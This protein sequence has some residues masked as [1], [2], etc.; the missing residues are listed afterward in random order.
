MGGFLS[1]ILPAVG[2]VL[3]TIGGSF[4]GAPQIGGA[5]GNQLGQAGSRGLNAGETTGNHSGGDV[6]Q[7]AFGTPNN[8]YNKNPDWVNTAS[9]NIFTNA[10]KAADQP[11]TPYTG[12]QV[13]PLSS[14]QQLAATNAANAVGRYAPTYGAI[15]DYYNQSA[16]PNTATYTAGAVTPT[17]VSTQN[18]NQADIG[19]YMN[20]YLQ[21]SLN[22]QINNLNLQYAN[23]QNQANAQAAGSGNF[24]GSR[25][26]VANALINKQQNQ[27]IQNVEANGYNNAFNTAASNW[28]ADQA[29]NLQGQLANQ[30]AGI[31]TGEFNQTQNANAFTTNQNIAQQNRLAQQAAAAGLTALTGQQQSNAN[32]ISNNLMTTGAAQQQTQQ[33]QD[34]AKYQDYLNQMYYPE[35]QAT[36]L[37]SILKGNPAAGSVGYGYSPGNNGQG[38]LLGQLTNGSGGGILGSITNGISG[39]FGGGSGSSASGT[40]SSSFNPSSIT[41]QFA[42]AGGGS[43]GLNF[44]SS[45]FANG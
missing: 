18:F 22:P 36:F 7:N 31:N 42:N 3:G 40:G 27:D 17:N 1:S 14:N 9:Q 23:Q 24:G 39:L 38:N 37:S 5:I 41:N 6:I 29:R 25:Q 21:A 32:A 12:Q 30:Q 15:T 2:T 20:P 13:A 28:Q 10:S 26:G 8:L 45:Q 44:D 34:A 35:Q 43:G 4:V 33:A 11:Y 16:Q 19:S